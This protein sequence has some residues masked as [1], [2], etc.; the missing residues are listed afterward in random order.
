MGNTFEIKVW[1]QIGNTGHY[2]NERFW[3][4]ESLF[5]ALWN[6]RKAKRLRYGCVTLEW[7]KQTLIN[8]NKGMNK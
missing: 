7:R 3:S 5:S 8:F 2:R 6:M 1:K 4:G